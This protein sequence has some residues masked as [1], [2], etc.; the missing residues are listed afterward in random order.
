VEQMTIKKI[1]LI[2]MSLLSIAAMFFQTPN[3]ASSQSSNEPKVIPDEAI[4]LRILANSNSDKD[5]EVKRM[6][7]DKMNAQITKWVEN[8]TS[9]EKSREVISAQIPELEE[10]VEGILEE[11][12]INQ[13]VSIEYGENVKFPTKIYGNYIYPAGEYEAVLV[14]L[15]DGKG[16]NWWCVLFPPLCF[17]DFSNAEAAN[18]EDPGT[19]VEGKREEI[20]V[21]FFV[22]ELFEKLLAKL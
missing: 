12:N 19:D 9:I 20:E 6:I 21:K 7:R 5:Q 3:P 22:V 8:L 14:T 15:G 10:L 11:E 18:G 4:R 1:V 13:S 16:A 2:Y 17:L